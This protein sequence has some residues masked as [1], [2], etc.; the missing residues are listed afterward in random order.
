MGQTSQKSLS[1]GAL[2]NTG[3]FI[4]TDDLDDDGAPNSN[5]GTFENEHRF[6]WV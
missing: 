1:T 5:T 2:L 3:N 4:M 6:D